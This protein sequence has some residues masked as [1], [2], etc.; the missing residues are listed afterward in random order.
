MRKLLPALALLLLSTFMAHAQDAPPAS[1]TVELRLLALSRAYVRPMAD[2]AERLARLEGVLSAEAQ[3]YADDVMTLKVSTTLG[4]AQLAA[5]L[6][7][8]LLRAEGLTVTLAPGEDLRSRRAEARAVIG[9]IG[10]AIAKSM[11]REN[12]DEEM[13]GIDFGA[14]DTIESRMRKLG[15][16]PAMLNGKWYTPADYRIEA[17]GEGRGDAYRIWAGAS[18]WEGMYVSRAEA[19]DDARV[20]YDPN[21]RFVGMVVPMGWYELPPTW[22]D[23]EGIM[24]SSTAERSDTGWTGELAVKSGSKLITEILQSAVAYRVRNP[25]AKLDTM[26][27]GRG[28]TLMNNL[29]GGDDIEY[30]GYQNFEI[31]DLQLSWRQGAEGS[32][33]A[34]VRAHTPAS[35]FYLDA[36]VDTGPVLKRYDES[37]RKVRRELT[38]A[39]LGDDLKWLFG[40][41]ADA[42]AFRD[43]RFEA[44]ETLNQL[45][46]ALVRVMKEK[47]A[48]A[49]DTLCG[50]LDNTELA[51]QLGIKGDGLKFFAA[52][53]F[54]IRKQMLGDVEVSVG[55]PAKGGRRWIVLNPASGEVIRRFQ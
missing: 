43:R 50:R 31:S 38:R 5:A 53:E 11:S 13:T 42:Q 12:P 20:D 48:T 26:P 2:T 15:L 45:A 44:R 1:R 41:E 47:P 55:S 10:A 16:D 35:A 52:A 24:L 19:G 29:P 28:Y 25:A 30:W 40:P 17:P 33:Y 7:M 36:E 9:R 27:S 39:N 51:V 49:L 54:E 34:R 18:N 46:D 23:G 8:Q 37:D 21:S 32:F 4:D 3:S 22:V 14:S 6:G